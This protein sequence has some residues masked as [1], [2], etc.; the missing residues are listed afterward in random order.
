MGFFR[1]DEDPRWVDNDDLKWSPDAPLFYGKGFATD[2]SFGNFAPE[3]PADEVAVPAPPMPKAPRLWLPRLVIGLAQGMGLFLLLQSRTLNQWPGNDGYL[4]SALALAGLFAPLLLLEGLGEIALPALLLWTAIAAAAL[5]SVGLYH[6]RRLQTGEQVHAGLGLIALAAL[7]LVI[8]QAWLRAGMRDRMIIASYRSCS[9]VTWTL[10]ARLLVWAAMAGMAWALVGSGNSLVNWLRAHYPDFHPAFDPSRL[11]LPLVGVAS[12]AA[13]ALTAGS[14]WTRRLTRNTLLACLTIALPVLGFGALLLLAVNLVIA[15]QP[16]WAFL[17]GATLL[18]IAVNASYRAGGRR[19]AWRRYSELA[20]AFLIAALAFCAALALRARVAELGWTHIRIYAALAV[21]MLALYGLA[22][23]FAALIGIGGGRWMQRIE[24]AN[25]AL[26][27]LLLVAGILLCT[28]LADPLKLAV[29]A[30]SARLANGAD[31]ATFDFAWLKQEGVRFGRQ[32]LDEMSRS[33][34][35]EIA[36]DATIAL[37]TTPDAAAP[38]P[39]QI[40]A[41]ITVRTPGA[42]LPETL[43]RRDWSNVPGAVPPCLTKPAL[44]CDAWFLDLDRDGAAEILLVYG[45]DARW[46]A[47]VMKQRPGGWVPAASFASPACRGTLSAMRKG[48]LYMVDPAP[49]WQDILVAGFRL[50]AKAGPKPDLPCPH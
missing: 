15:P 44:A 14:S 45:T 35:P 16:L 31:P 33:A 13:F 41:N 25:R 6:H 11:V 43:L 4:F 10:A 30:Q 39:S 8:A 2:D 19:G 32:A 27:L 23:S 48:D 24:P 47:S 5:S 42:R 28:P 22:Y 26:A 18:L 21:A 46:W 3:R 38:P 34:A 12:A 50:T 49:T 9:D 20:A 7:A 37:S 36:R 29:N 17:T 40:G 1:K